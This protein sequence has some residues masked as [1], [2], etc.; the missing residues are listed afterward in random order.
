MFLDIFAPFAWLL[1][2]LMIAKSAGSNREGFDT[3]PSDGD[4]WSAK[5]P[6][7]LCFLISNLRIPIVVVVVSV[8]VVVVLV[9]VVAAVVVVVSFVIVVRYC[10]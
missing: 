9:V 3:F 7:L 4:R 5:L 1:Y 2:L 6:D 10:L 8:A